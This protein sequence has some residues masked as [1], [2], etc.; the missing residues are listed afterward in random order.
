MAKKTPTKSRK[1]PKTAPRKTIAK[2]A[3]RKVDFDDKETVLKEVCK[4]LDIDPSDCQIRMGSAPNGYGSAYTISEGRHAEY[5]VM[6]NEEDFEAAAREGVENDLRDE[7]SNFNSN[8]IESH[9]DLNKLR[10]ALHS[11]VSDSNFDSLQ[12][13]A[14]RHPMKFLQDNNLDIPSPSEKQLRD[15]AEVASDDE[16]SADAIYAELLEKDPEDQW[17]AIGEEPEVSN[18]DL[19]DVANDMATA[20]L[21]DPLEYLVDIYGRQEAPK[22]A[23]EIA[24]IDVEKA[25]DEAVSTDGAAH[26]MCGYDGNYDTTKSGFIVW[27]HN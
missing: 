14:D 3:P 20:Q 26:F 16:K 10:D 22:K 13:E 21:R 7:P 12:D 1:S 19:T 4:E 27:R 2:R 15:C 8:F 11:D 24:G 25:A 5:I 6:E 23:I 17:D 18:S 9:I